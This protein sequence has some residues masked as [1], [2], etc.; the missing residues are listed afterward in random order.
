MCHE[1]LFQQNSSGSRTYINSHSYFIHRIIEYNHRIS[2]AGRGPEGSLSLMPAPAQG[3]PKHH[4]MCLRALSQCSWQSWCCDHFCSTLFLFLIPSLTPLT[5]L[6]A[7]CSSPI[8]GH[9]RDQYLP[10]HFPLGG[11]YRQWLDLPPVTS[12]VGRTSQVTSV[13]QHWKIFERRLN[14]DHNRT[15]LCIDFVWHVC[16]NLYS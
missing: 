6:H 2:W 7:I 10:L 5:E 1:S 12:S 15:V 3:S 9:Q 16:H 14:R 11:R 4:S 8:A 13:Q